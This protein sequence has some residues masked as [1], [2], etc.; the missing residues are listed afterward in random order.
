MKYTNMASPTPQTEPLDERQVKNNAGGYTY[1]V[2][3]ADRLRRFLI[4]GTEGGT[5]YAGQGDHTKQALGFL[6]SMAAKDPV[7]YWG[8]LFEAASLNLAPRHSPTLYAL[9]VLRRTTRDEWVLREIKG[10]F[11]SI[12]RTGTHL[13]EYV[14]YDTSM[15]GW[16]RGLRNLVSDWYL[17]E[18]TPEALAYQVVKYRQRGGWT[19][20]DLLRLAHPSTASPDERHLDP[21]LDYIANGYRT[22]ESTDKVTSINEDILPDVIQQFENV[23]AGSL[24]ASSADK[25][26]WEMLP[27]EDLRDPHTWQ[28]LIHQD[29]L[30]FTAM[31]RNLGRMTA[32]GAL[33]PGTIRRVVGVL[34]DPERVRRSRMHPFNAL[35]A[36]KTY[37]SGGGFRG[38][39][40]WTPVPRISDA[41]SDLFHLSFQNVEPSGK[42]IMVAVD[43]SGSMH[44]TRLMNSNVNAMEG[45]VAMAQTLQAAAPDTT[46]VYAFSDGGRSG[47]PV[48]GSQMSPLSIS[49]RQRLDDVLRVLSGMRFGRTDCALPMVEAAAWGKEYDA[50]IVLTDNETWAGRVH[51]MAALKAYRQKHVRDA[52]LAVVGMTAT[53]FTIAD[54]ADSGTLDV[55]GFDAS[56]P[57]V[58]MDFIEGRF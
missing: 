13:F 53:S 39:L 4:L 47:P 19:H 22:I 16:G 10:H 15:G 38:S 21:V 14:D 27:S 34:T 20:R 6:Q 5:Y 49:P 40:Q 17:S 36:L 9:A 8:V 52:R 33:Q 30:P 12:V 51:P 24:D 41:L 18:R 42:R 45:A 32:N 56:G 44:F 7:S 48:I 35:T 58:I 37:T 57:R 46:D 55:A 23:R 29:R 50:F 1:E 11:N 43:V 26:T 31:V 3:D 54:P 28:A 25:L 2:L